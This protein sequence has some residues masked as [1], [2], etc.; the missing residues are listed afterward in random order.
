MSNCPDATPAGKP[1]TMARALGVA[2]L[3]GMLL[4][5]GCVD[6]APWAADDSSTIDSTPF[7]PP[8]DPSKQP[9]AGDGGNPSAIPSPKPADAINTSGWKTFATQGLS[10]KYPPDWNIEEDDC[11]NCNATAKP[12]ADPF[13]KWDI[14]DAD[15]NEIAEFRAD[16]AT[17]TDGD[18]STYQRT[19]LESTP[20]KAD[21]LAPAEVVFEHFVLHTRGKETE[22]KVLLMLNDAAAT[23]ARDESPALSFFRPKK[24]FGSQMTSS[25]DLAEELGFDDDHVSLADA[26]KIMASRDYRLLRAVMLSMRVE[27]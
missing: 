7:G 11:S 15:G 20:V 19:V 24:D 25:D 21:F 3:L 10:F 26:R 9:V 1:K 17:D 13:T 18:M 22:Q 23:K 4:L 2:S 14:E 16:S 5:S 27:K 8:Q 6:V 12:L